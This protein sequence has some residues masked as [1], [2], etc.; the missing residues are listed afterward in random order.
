M[1]Q[2]RRTFPELDV[3][4]FNEYW[5]LRFDVA[6]ADRLMQF[7]SQHAGIPACRLTS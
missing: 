2:R 4:Q 5:E 7:V 6:L 1:A 3:V